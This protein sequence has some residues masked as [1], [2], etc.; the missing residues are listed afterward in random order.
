MNC[1]ELAQKVAEL[2]P[3]AQPR[4]IARLVLLLVNSV[5][6]IDEFDQEQVLLD[7][8]H[9]VGLRLQAATDQHTA[10]TQELESLAK[11]DPRRFAPEQIWVLIRSI[12]VQSQILRLYVGD[13]SFDLC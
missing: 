9:E 2:Q 1:A 4:D 12:K 6:S 8:W 3:D 10:M 11:S 5:E 7:A 13:P